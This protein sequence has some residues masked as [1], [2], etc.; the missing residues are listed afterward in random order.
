[1]SENYYVEIL[2]V[3]DSRTRGLEDRLNRTSSNLRFTV[4]T[5]PGANLK[6][7]ML[8]ILA[9]L[10]YDNSYHLVFVVG[11]I[12]NMTRLL[13]NPSR[14]AVPRF[15]SVT[16]LVENTLSAMRTAL[17]KIT[18]ITEIP[19]VLASLPGMD[20]SAYSP[21]YRDLLTPL[22]ATLDTAITMINLRVRGMNRLNNA[23]T[24]NLAYPVHR[25]K[26][27]NANFSKIF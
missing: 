18:A 23:Q 20:L 16:D 3:G 4:F 17:D 25:C 22:Q 11:G 26:G 13:H 8:K 21:D 5:L 24:L 6:T 15:R 10:S 7:I 1:M 14:H 27:K 19:V 2:I 12:N 9:T